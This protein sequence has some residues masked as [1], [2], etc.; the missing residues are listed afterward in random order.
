LPFS[1]KL[2]SV[3]PLT[4]GL[5]GGIASGKSQVSQLFAARAIEIIDADEIARDLLKPDSPLLKPLKARF[6]NAIFDHNA[7][8][9]RKALARIVFDSKEQLQWLNEL[10]HPQ[11]AKGM[12]ARLEK[13]TSPYVIL[14]IP[15]LID[16]TGIIPAHLKS[17]VDRVLVVDVS[18]QL[19]I[20]RIIKRDQRTT[21]EAEAIIANQSSREQKLTLA[22][23]V[24]DNSG[25]V[26]ALEPQVELLH[27]R[28]ME[29][30]RKPL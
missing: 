14:D 26:E 19:Q 29:M 5:T 12:R 6:G 11:V 23:D 27:N 4:I 17:L 21:L 9:N 28:Y 24:L 13:A 8:L 20:E 30:C 3:K 22:D 18:P 7:I 25:P 1:S 16:Q 15:L 10:M 2:N